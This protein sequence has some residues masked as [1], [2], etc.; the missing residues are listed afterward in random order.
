MNSISALSDL[1]LPDVS[2]GSDEIPIYGAGT[3]FQ[4]LV[5]NTAD[6]G[7]AILV[8]AVS[9][10]VFGLIFA[11]FNLGAAGDNEQARRKA[12]QQILFS[13]ISIALLGGLQVVLGLASFTANLS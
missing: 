11:L 1:L 8:V 10:A 6:L 4:G 2:L 7:N 13:G 3:T 9:A 12:M 5:D